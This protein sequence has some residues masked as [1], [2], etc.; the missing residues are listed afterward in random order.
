VT[1]FVMLTREQL[2]EIVTSA[3]EQATADGNGYQKLWLDAK[4][5]ADHLGI[6]AKT[7]HNRTAPSVA[8]PIPFHTLTPGGR[9]MFHR[10]EVD[11]WLR[12]REP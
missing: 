3:V 9:K 8:N 12:R 1:E 7:V 11:E 5:L 4:E 6:S 2:E 10:G